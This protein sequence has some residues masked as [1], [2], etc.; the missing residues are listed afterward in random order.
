LTSPQ[1]L[2][3]RDML[4]LHTRGSAE[5]LGIDEH[6]GTLRV[7]RYADFLV[8]DPRDPGTGPARMPTGPTSWPA[9][10]GT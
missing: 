4:V 7:R 10:C 5:G 3:V 9:R 1:R 8:V 6:V 2:P